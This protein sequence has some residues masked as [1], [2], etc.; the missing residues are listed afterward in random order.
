MVKIWQRNLARVNDS[1]MEVL[2]VFGD[3]CNVAAL[4][5]VLG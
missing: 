5:Q 4:L 2:A 1:G 3:R